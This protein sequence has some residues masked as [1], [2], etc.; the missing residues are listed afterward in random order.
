MRSL[1]ANGLDR[2]F[3][4][5]ADSIFPVFFPDLK[6]NFSDSDE[7]ENNYSH[8]IICSIVAKSFVGQLFINVNLNLLKQSSKELSA[9]P[10]DVILKILNETS[11]QLLGIIAFNLNK[12]NLYGRVGL[13]L[14]IQRS[15]YSPGKLFVPSIKIHDAS[16]AFMLKF[17]FLDTEGN[18]R[19]DF[20]KIK[21][22]MPQDDVD[23]L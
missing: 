3:K 15:T 9:Q 7:S 20:T 13:P 5:S 12:L 8:L 22:E 21:C 4:F 11:N 17:G 10:D 14:D 18:Q 23:F 19:L 1:V 2:L 16:R 6:F